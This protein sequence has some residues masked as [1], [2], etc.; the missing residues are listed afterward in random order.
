MWQEKKIPIILSVVLHIVIFSLLFVKFPHSKTIASKNVNIVQAVAINESQLQP[1]PQPPKSTVPT[2]PEDTIRH[3]E[4]TTLKQNDVPKTEVAKTLP[5][6]EPPPKPVEEVK[7]EPVEMEQP[8]IDEALQKQKLLEIA[9]KKEEQKRKKEIKR[10][11]QE[12]AKQRRAEEALNLQKALAAETKAAKTEEESTADTTDK[13]QEEES[14]STTE[15]SEKNEPSKAQVSANQEGEV[16]KYKQM[17]VQTISRKWIMPETE[18][19]NIACQLLVHL[20]PG[21]V[22]LSVDLLKESGDENLDRSARN[23][24]MKASPL[25]VPDNL[26]LFDNFRALRLTF[27]PQG[28]VSG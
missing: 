26:D 11:E 25:P 22:V 5:K 1:A 24:I 4:Q 3:I 19:K 16:D 21:G 15:T 2:L 8:K 20:G 7:S 28:I 27:R 17:I 13:D 10:H 18:D 12:L 23:A 6:E 9:K 14:E